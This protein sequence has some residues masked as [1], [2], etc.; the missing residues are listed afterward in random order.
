MRLLFCCEFYYPSVGGVQEVMR[1]IAERL[2]LRGHDV[3]VATT[4]LAERNVDEYNGVKIVQFGVTGNLVRGMEGE[5]ELYRQF[6]RTFECDAILIKAAQQWTFDALWPVLD[7][8]QARKV[9]IPCGFSGLFEPSY[10]SYFD[11]I[12]DVLR[13]FD[14]LIFYTEKYRD[15]D[16]A[17]RHNINHFSIIPNGASESEFGAQRDPTFRQRNGIPEDSAVLLTVGSM[18]GMKGHKELLEAFVHLKTKRRHVT[19]IMNGNIPSNPLLL[20][21]KENL[22][23]KDSRE[24]ST[25]RTAYSYPPL[26]CRVSKVYQVEGLEGVAKKSLQRVYFILNTI[27]KLFLKT[28]RVYREEGMIGVRSRILRRIGTCLQ[29][30]EL[31]NYLPAAVRASLNPMSYWMAEAQRTSNNKKLVITDLSRE[32]LVQAYL[33]ADLFVFA[34]NI[35]YSPLV[36]FEAAA[37]GLPFLSVPVGNSEEIAKWTGCGLICPAEKDDR[38][39]TRVAPTVLATEIAKAIE[40]GPRLK[41]LGRVGHANWRENFTWDVIAARY[42]ALLILQSP[43]S[44]KD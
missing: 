39:Y 5:V 35:E 1:Q 38:G 24:Q 29:D 16:F 7:A 44:K 41:E 3:T 18:T 2:V 9:F 27:Q 13:K 36:L 14:H 33:S 26:W 34:S 22:D 37:A 21:H 23:S 17:R 15:V 28:I 30:S 43:K 31:L 20:S 42:E 11:K 8:K 32:E 10:S 40:D 12:P 6:V 4:R 25:M 19:L